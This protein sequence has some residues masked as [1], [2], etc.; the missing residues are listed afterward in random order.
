M[1]SE[2]LRE[3]IEKI[4]EHHTCEDVNG[5]GRCMLFREEYG[6]IKVLV[7]SLVSLVE[8]EKEKA[9]KKGVADEIE[10]WNVSGE[11]DQEK[12]E[13]AKQDLLELRKIADNWSD[14]N[15]VEHCRISLRAKIDELI[16]KK[17][18]QK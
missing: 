11:H 15:T 6:E 16:D 14:Y 10:C 9:Y 17:N 4:C 18:V 12:R 7:D 1:K 2:P 3:K 5:E 8:E 13:F